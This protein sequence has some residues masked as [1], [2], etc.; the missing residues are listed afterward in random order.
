MLSNNPHSKELLMTFLFFLA[1]A[2]IICGI[3]IL[4]VPAALIV[5]GILIIFILF[6]VEYAKIE[7]K[8]ANDKK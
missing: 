3:A 8:D 5:G 2:C 7:G 4:S 6:C 1:F